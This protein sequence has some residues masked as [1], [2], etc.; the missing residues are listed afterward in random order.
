M[1]RLY[2]T[3]PSVAREMTHRESLKPSAENVST[4]SL[5]DTASF[6]PAEISYD[7]NMELAWRTFRVVTRIFYTSL[8]ELSPAAT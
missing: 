3:E 4:I 1:P 5:P 7:W 6:A 2:E 8:L